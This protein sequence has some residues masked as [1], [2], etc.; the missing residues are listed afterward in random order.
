M[1]FVVFAQVVVLV[2]GLNPITLVPSE[3]DDS[4]RLDVLQH[5]AKRC[6]LTGGEKVWYT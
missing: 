1:S 2:A 4:S 5:P 6:L 3:R